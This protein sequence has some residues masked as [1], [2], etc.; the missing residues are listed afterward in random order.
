MHTLVNFTAAATSR[1]WPLSSVTAPC[2]PQG[3]GLLPGLRVS[4]GCLGRGAGWP[5]TALGQAPQPHPLFRCLS[6][7]HCCGDGWGPGL[8]TR[9][10]RPWQQR[11]KPT[12]RG[13]SRAPAPPLRLLWE[14]CSWGVFP[15]LPAGSGLQGS[16]GVKHPWAGSTVLVSELAH[17]LVTRW[18]SWFGGGH[19]LRPVPRRPLHTRAVTW[20]PGRERPETHVHSAPHS[21]TAWRQC[22]RAALVPTAHW[23]RACGSH[24]LASSAASL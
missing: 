19:A 8:P 9:S 17:V 21:V 5:G 4:R 23:P 11:E 14:G 1:A 12:P 20:G 18:R 3:E 10:S 6:R 24:A 7:P 16:F 22:H 2:C 13:E 15:A